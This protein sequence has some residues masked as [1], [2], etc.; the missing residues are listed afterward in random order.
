ME[1][2]AYSRKIES[3]EPQKQDATTVFSKEDIST[4]VESTLVPLEGPTILQTLEIPYNQV[5]VSRNPHAE[6]EKVH[7][8][9]PDTTEG[10]EALR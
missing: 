7:L 8:P 10:Y 5:C 4:S 6:L 9:W 3:A 2:P 1:K